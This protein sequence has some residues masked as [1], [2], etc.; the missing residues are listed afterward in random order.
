MN[1]FALRPGW[2]PLNI[3]LMVVA[4]IIYW[5]LGLL[6]LAY[7]V[8]GDRL[9]SLVAD[10]KE[11]LGMNGSSSRAPVFPGARP[12]ATGPVQPTGN[13]AFDDYRARELARLEEERRK[14]DAMREEFD[15]YLRDLRR[16]RD[17]EEFDRFMAS[18]NARV[19]EAR[20]ERPTTGVPGT[21]DR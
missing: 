14:L 9:P 2:N 18:R 12:A 10:A 13:V 19:D 20:T 21:G 15:D 6:M 16:A 7:I 3:A 8:W 5:P 17:R 11:K 1:S 4:F